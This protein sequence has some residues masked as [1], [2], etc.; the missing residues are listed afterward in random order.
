MFMEIIFWMDSLERKNFK[1]FWIGFEGI[2]HFFIFC[3]FLVFVL[4]FKVF[5]R[6]F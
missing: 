3:L 6:L 4:K 5:S 2:C 1:G